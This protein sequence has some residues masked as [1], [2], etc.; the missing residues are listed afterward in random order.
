M[1]GHMPLSAC[2]SPPA[3]CR[4]LPRRGVLYRRLQDFDAAVEDFLRALDMANDSQYDTVRQA[5]RQLLLTYNDFAVLCYKQGAYQ[6]G[7]LLLNKALR[8][9][10]REKGLYINRGGARGGGAGGV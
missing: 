7:V 6:K 1:S 2:L 3:T 5:Q 4:A 10:Q 8:G 9:E